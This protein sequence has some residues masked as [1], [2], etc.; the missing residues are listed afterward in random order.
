MYS[1]AFLEALSQDGSYPGYAVEID[2][3]DGISRSHTGIG[4]IVIGGQTFLGVGNMGSVGAVTENGDA[5]PGRVA[6]ELKGIPGDEMSSLFTAQC[7]GRAVTLYICVW[8]AQ[9]QLIHA[10]V[11]LSGTIVNYNAKAGVSN[12]ISITV[13]DKFELFE[14]PWQKRWSDESHK[15]DHPDDRICRYVAQMADREVHWGSK[16]DAPPFN[17]S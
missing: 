5:K 2:W 15:A 10:E 12:K 4:E 9:G 17:Y 16:K 8:N 6:L 13:A 7:R 1:D 3:P 11:T 14:R